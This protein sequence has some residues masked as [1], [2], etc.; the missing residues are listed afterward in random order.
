MSLTFL[1][2]GACTTFAA[3]A[4]LLLLGVTALDATTALATGFTGSFRTT[5]FFDAG[6]VAEAFA[7]GLRASALR[8][9]A[10]PDFNLVV[11]MITHPRVETLC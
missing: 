9:T 8:V 6:L 4:F 3:T 7:T 1:G 11:V 5:G 2:V 10:A